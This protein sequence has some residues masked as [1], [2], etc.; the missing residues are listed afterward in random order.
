M[1]SANFA[2]SLVLGHRC[3]STVNLTTQKC[4]EPPGSLPNGLIVLPSPLRIKIIST[5]SSLI[6]MLQISSVPL[7]L[8]SIYVHVHFTNIN[9]VQALL[10]PLDHEEHACTA[11]TW[12]T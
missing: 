7:I 11:K 9:V 10:A 12:T 3:E 1:G 2:S 8:A 6:I 5:D 4:M